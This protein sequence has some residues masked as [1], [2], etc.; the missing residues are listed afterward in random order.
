MDSGDFRFLVWS[1]ILISSV[2]CWAGLL[3]A[4]CHWEESQVPL[5]FPRK[6]ALL[7]L[8]GISRELVPQGRDT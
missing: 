7:I 5:F 4:L 6:H 3:L 8:S 2:C 1:Y